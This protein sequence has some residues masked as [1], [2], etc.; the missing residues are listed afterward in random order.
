MEKNGMKGIPSHPPDFGARITPSNMPPNNALADAVVAALKRAGTAAL[1]KQELADAINP[2]WSGAPVT[3][4]DVNKALYSLRERGEVR[5]GADMHGTKPTW[6]I[7]AAEDDELAQPTGPVVESADVAMP[8]A[9]E[10]A[11]HEVREQLGE[12][13]IDVVE[14]DACAAA[15]SIRPHQ[16]ARQLQGQGDPGQGELRDDRIR[17]LGFVR[18][19]REPDAVHGEVVPFRPDAPA[20]ADDLDPALV[21]RTRTATRFHSDSG[22]KIHASPREAAL[23]PAAGT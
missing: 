16:L 11:G 21:G 20:L 23:S 10:A 17:D 4:K 15:L 2:G 1:D 22:R 19:E 14:A 8:A 3:A 7:A 12:A 13:R 6:L 18:S 5:T 9:L